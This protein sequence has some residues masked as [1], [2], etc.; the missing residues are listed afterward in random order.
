LAQGQPRTPQMCDGPQITELVDDSIEVS[1]RSAFTGEV[2]ITPPPRLAP[3]DT[4][5]D[6]RDRV[7]QSAS[8][9]AAGKRTHLVMDG[10]RLSYDSSPVVALGFYSGAVIDAVFSEIHSWSL[11][12]KNSPAK[13]F[14]LTNYAYACQAD[15]DKICGEHAESPL[16]ID[17]QGCILNLKANPLP[18]T[19]GI[20]LNRLHR[21]HLHVVVGQEVQVKQF[22]P[23]P[24]RIVS[25]CFVLVQPFRASEQVVVY[26][27]DLTKRF[28]Q[29]FNLQLVTVGQHLALDMEPLLL[30][31]TISSLTLVGYGA[32]I[33]QGFVSDALRS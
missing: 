25:H 21:Q 28:L 13:N 5:E 3:T 16:F 33:D 24:A 12:I 6:L 27:E 20:C 26:V 22:I 11:T 10:R 32:R 18:Q 2:L 15:I 8:V 9:L 4:V 19:G 29:Q 14:A 31:I 7:V 17:I 1:L 23:S 30:K